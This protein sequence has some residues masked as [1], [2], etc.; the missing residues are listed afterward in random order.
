MEFCG[1]LNL[2]VKEVVGNIFFYH[3]HNFLINQITS[4]MMEKKNN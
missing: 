3:R 1:G 4:F 2:M